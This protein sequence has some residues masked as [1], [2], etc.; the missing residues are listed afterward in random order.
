MFVFRCSYLS[1][2]PVLTFLSSAFCFALTYDVPLLASFSCPLVRFKAP[3]LYS[4]SSSSSSSSFYFF[5]FLS[6]IFVFFSFAGEREGEEEVPVSLYAYKRCRDYF[7]S[8]HDVGACL[9]K[10]KKRDFIEQTLF[11]TSFYKY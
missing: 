1:P 4:S 10:D 2:L 9:F 8:F 3:A 7:T 11:F 5:C 6:L